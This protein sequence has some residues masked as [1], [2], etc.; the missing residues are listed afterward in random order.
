VQIQIENLAE[1]EFVPQNFISHFGGFWAI[2]YC[3]FTGH[4]PQKSPTINGS[5]AENVLQLK[6][7]YGSRHP[8]PNSFQQNFSLLFVGCCSV[9]SFFH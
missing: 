5:S 9:W 2:G 3:I 1:F 7:S 4:V 8:A 6:A